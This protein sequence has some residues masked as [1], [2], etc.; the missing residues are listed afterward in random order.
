MLTTIASEGT[1]RADVINEDARGSITLIKYN[2]VEIYTLSRTRRGYARGG[3]YHPTA[4]HALLLDGEADW[5]TK[6]PDGKGG[7]EFVTRT[8]EPGSDFVIAPGVPHSLEAK[9]DCTVL[10]WQEGGGFEKGI[11]AELRERVLALMR[12]RDRGEGI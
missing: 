12:G 3:D 2:N 5:T 8:H 11:D 6:I 9:T 7:Y 4:Q 10:M 1:F